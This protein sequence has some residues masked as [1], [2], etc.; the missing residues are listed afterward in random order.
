MGSK[1]GRAYKKRFVEYISDELTQIV[2]EV[3]LTVLSANGVHVFAALHS[4]QHW[5]SKRLIIPDF[6]FP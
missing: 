1:C 5:D 6:C 2:T 4:L 3:T